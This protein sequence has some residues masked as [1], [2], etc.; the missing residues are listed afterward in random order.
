MCINIYLVVIC[1]VWVSAETL[2]PSAKNCLITELTWSQLC[3]HNYVRALFSELT[4]FSWTSWTSWTIWTSCW[5]EQVLQAVTVKSSELDL[6]VWR[7]VIHLFQE[8]ANN[9][10]MLCRK[11]ILIFDHPPPH[12]GDFHFSDH[13]ND[14]PFFFKLIWILRCLADLKSPSVHYKHNSNTIRVIQKAIINRASSQDSSW[15]S[16]CQR[17]I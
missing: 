9:I 15:P 7:D 8:T 17:Q 14:Q 10:I 1:D 2:P 16:L 5:C 6:H 11:W 4:E 12:A 13:L 3:L